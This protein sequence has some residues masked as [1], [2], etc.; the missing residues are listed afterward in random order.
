[1]A[2]R[3]PIETIIETFAAILVLSPQALNGMA[4]VHSITTEQIEAEVPIE[5]VTETVSVVLSSD[6]EL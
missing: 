2:W 1:M 6:A 3:I 5:T 4:P